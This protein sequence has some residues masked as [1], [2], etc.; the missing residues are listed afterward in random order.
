MITSTGVHDLSLLDRFSATNDNEDAIRFY[1][2]W[3][4]TVSQVISNAVDLARKI[5]PEI[6]LYNEKGVPIKDEIVFIKH[7]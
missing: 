4:Y 5:K 1:Q 2:H 3:A 6:P 7:L